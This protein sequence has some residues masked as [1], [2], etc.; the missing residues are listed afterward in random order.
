MKRRVAVHR[1]HSDAEVTL[2]VEQAELRS[3][4]INYHQLADKTGMSYEVVR[5]TV[6]RIVAEIRAGKLRVHRGITN[7]ELVAKELGL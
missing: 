7:C 2:L 1:N 3:K 6:G 4:L 5:Q